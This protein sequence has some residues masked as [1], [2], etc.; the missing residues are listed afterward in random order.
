MKDLR[1]FIDNYRFLFNYFGKY[2]KTR[3]IAMI[4][5]AFETICEMLVPA[6]MGIIVNEAVNNKDL[7]KAIKIGIL[8]IV[9]AL[10]GMFCGMQ[11]TKYSGITSSGAG[12]MLRLAQFNNIE[13][14]SFSDLDYFT[15]PSLLTRIT[16]DTQQTAMSVFM[17]TRFIIKTVV[18]AA[19][20]F[21]LSIRT[22]L[23]LSLIFLVG[24]PIL[25]FFVII[26]LNKAVPVFKKTRGQFDK[27]N[28]TLEENLRN[29]R[30]VKAFVR[31]EYEKNKFYEVN[32]GL[33]SL[34]YRGQQLMATIFPL[35]SVILFATFLAIM[36]IGGTEIIN[37]NLEVG[38]LVSFNIYSMMLMGSYI[39]LTMVVA[40]LMQ[41]SAG[42]TRIKEVI[43]HTPSMSNEKALE[44]LKLKDGSIEFN[45]V[46]FHFEDE[47]D[48]NALNNIDIKI[49]SGESIG[50]L[51]ATGSSKSILV[52][53]IPRLYDITDGELKISGENIENYDLLAL[54]DDVAIVLQ[55]NTL[56]SGT[57]EENLKW[58]N[59]D[60]SSKEVEEAAKI[61]QAHEF[62]VERPDGYQSMLGQG[63]T[64]VSGGQKQRLCIARALLKNPKIL[65]LDNSTSAVDTKTE[66]LI[67]KGINQFNKDLTKIIISQRVSSFEE[68][69]RII[70]MEEGHII[71]IGDHEYLM[72]KNELYRKTY[73]FQN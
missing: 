35:S 38:Q 33:F 18:I 13:K 39:G 21:I 66:S 72:R 15:V 12:H 57:I 3:N 20:A 24:T 71:D 56:F 69:D 60:A 68:C 53:M 41:S 17:S 64:G 62:I 1:E 29:I 7:A 65:I 51:G 28:L 22:S 23:K 50:I 47:K 61:A 26:I 5:T 59:P 40:Q 54:R 48:V 9:L 42:M 30:V 31:Q 32:H 4:Y 8:M 58:G 25:F 46:S 67:M 27:I 14:F 11:G 37:G 73:E 43:S 16:S 36:W 63:G 49:K 10:I 34:A 44:G 55:K 6:L 2:Q 70:V 19:S 45:N 52:Q